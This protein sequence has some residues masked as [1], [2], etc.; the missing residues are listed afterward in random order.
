MKSV[1]QKDQMPQV[2]Q[3]IWKVLMKAA[4]TLARPT[5]FIQRQGKVTGPGFAQMLVLGFLSDPNAS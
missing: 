5:G 4:E 1:S 3:A 2:E